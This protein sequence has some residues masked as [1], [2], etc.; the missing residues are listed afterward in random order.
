MSFQ[1][2]TDIPPREPMPGFVGR[3]IH[4][5]RVTVAFWEVPDGAVL[6]EHAHPHEQIVTVLEGRIELTVA[7]RSEILEPGMVAVIPGDTPHSARALSAC[8][9]QDIFQPPRDDYR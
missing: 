1:T 6:P 4:T 8:R 5:D 7:G 3:F 9:V 2:L